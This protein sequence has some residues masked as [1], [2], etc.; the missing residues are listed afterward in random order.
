MAT[1]MDTWFTIGSVALVETSLN[2]TRSIK[3]TFSR[4]IG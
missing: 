2:V 1:I 4:G 3:I